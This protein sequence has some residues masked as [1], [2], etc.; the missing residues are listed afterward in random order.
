[1]GNDGKV[2]TASTDVGVLKARF[3]TER[4]TS[5]MTLNES[6]K[7]SR[8]AFSKPSKLTIKDDPIPAWAL[9]ISSSLPA[10]HASNP[11]I[12]LSTA[13]AKASIV[14]VLLWPPICDG[15]LV[16]LGGGSEALAYTAETNLRRCSMM[17]AVCPRDARM[18]AC[19]ERV[20]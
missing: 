14:R 16:A 1:M 5:N 2:H 10:H 9:Q 20:R 15:T 7:V 11:C 12:S 6:A 17:V 18:D 3:L 19:D 13:S 8:T 4:M